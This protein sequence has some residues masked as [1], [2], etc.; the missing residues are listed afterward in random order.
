M[1]KFIIFDVMGVVFTVG[2]DVE[3]LLIPYIQSLNP[4][5]SAQ[6][7]KDAYHQTSLGRMSSREL[8]E[9]MG[10]EQNDILCIERDYL[11]NA[12]TLD[13]GFLACAKALKSKYGLALLSNDISEWSKYLRNFYDIEPL[14]NAAFI[15]GDL[16]VR[17]PD[18]QIYQIALDT[19]GVQPSECVF[20]DDSPE[21]VEAARRLGICSI[22]FNREEHDYNGLRVKSFD[23]LT[24]LLM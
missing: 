3:G 16:G 17:K 10:F 19:L 15:S 14:I 24:Q 21:R 13:D 1:I 6:K 23:Q 7:V 8:W 5:I 12:F 2:D 4:E 18:S 20:I 9:L 11:E 22:L